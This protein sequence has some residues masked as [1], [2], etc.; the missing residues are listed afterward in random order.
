MIGLFEWVEHLTVHS[1]SSECGAVVYVSLF[2]SLSFFFL[3]LFTFILSLLS[4]HA[5]KK[6]THVCLCMY[7]TS[8]LC[9]VSDVHTLQA[10]ASHS[11]SQQLP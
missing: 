3:S 4:H 6:I 8:L 7:V 11:I 10:T 2:F 1:H 5:C 9:F